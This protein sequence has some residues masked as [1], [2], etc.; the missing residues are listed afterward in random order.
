MKTAPRAGRCFFM[1][2]AGWGDWK[3]L[4]R[5]MWQHLVGYNMRND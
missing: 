2:T 5:R 1:I 4:G 3:L